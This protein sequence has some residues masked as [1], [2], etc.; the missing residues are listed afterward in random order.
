M[1]VKL[2]KLLKNIIS[3]PFFGGIFQFVIG[4]F[5]FAHFCSCLIFFSLRRFDKKYI[6]VAF[7]GPIHSNHFK[8]FKEYFCFLLKEKY[9]KNING[10]FINSY[11]NSHTKGMN[12]FDPV[13]DRFSYFFQGNFLS[14]EH[15]TKEVYTDANN[16]FNFV[17]K[18]Y[19]NSL[20]RFANPKYIFIHDLQ[21]AGYL[22]ADQLNDLKK[23]K[24]KVVCQAWGNDLRFFHESPKHKVKLQKILKNTDFLHTE[25]KFEHEIAKR[26]LFEGKLLEPCSVTF[27]NLDEFLKIIGPIKN[28]EKD[29]YLNI[30]SGYKFRQ[31]LYYVYLNFYN[32][33]EFWRN[34]KIVI[35][36]PSED[37]QFMFSKL[38]SKGFSI[39]YKKGLNFLE[40]QT[41]L[42]RSKYHLSS[43]LSD[44]VPNSIVESVFHGCIPLFTDYTGLC[45]YLD[46]S[47]LE[48]VCY[49]HLN[50]NL[51]E[52]FEA[53]DKSNNEK[54]LNLF[55]HLIKEKV[56]SKINYQKVLSD[57]IE[58][59]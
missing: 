9:G 19:I 23:N 40:F 47:T 3:T 26:N 39:S 33:I 21:T 13:L 59:S 41:L 54:I 46:E 48:K 20:L 45:E 8:N 50:Y 11:L 58:N 49:S 12:F 56:Y 32:N 52:K 5:R 7:C 22:L 42:S 35:T 18:Q 27:Q 34:K 30:K 17:S 24:T 16:P 55:K 14:D 28:A 2:R 38:I 6:N 43:N 51:T 57:I 36:N 1:I 25:T 10:I 4:I 37:D 53:L 31:N 44:G 15:W 29:I